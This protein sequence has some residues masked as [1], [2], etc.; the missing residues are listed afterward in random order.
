MDLGERRI[1]SS[2]GA[3]DLDQVPELML[4]I[5]AGVIG[6]ELGSVWRRLGSKVIVVELLDRILPGMDN[7]VCRQV[8]RIFER[9]GMTVQLASQGTRFA[10]EG[11][12]FKG[13]IAPAGS[14][15]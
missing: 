13:T 7:E 14:G 9:Q 3:L 5:G 15:S 1:V 4:V 2:A 11:K 8:Q 6:L 12:K 10:R